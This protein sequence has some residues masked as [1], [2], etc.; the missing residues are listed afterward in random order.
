MARKPTQIPSADRSAFVRLVTA[1]AK[2]EPLPK[3][4]VPEAGTKCG[5][6]VSQV[7]AI[8]ELA[9]VSLQVL[10]QDPIPRVEVGGAQRS[11]IIAPPHTRQPIKL[12]ACSTKLTANQQQ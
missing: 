6:V 7:M 1:M 11:H 4:T 9:Q 2:G 10:L 3:G 12:S 8:L 5:R